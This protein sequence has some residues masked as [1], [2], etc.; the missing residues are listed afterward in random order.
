MKRLLVVAG[1]SL[2][3]AGGCPVPQTSTPT[4]TALLAYSSSAGPAPLTIAFSGTSSTSPYGSIAGYYWDFGDGQFSAAASPFHIFQNPG[5]YNVI[6]TVTD[7]SGHTGVDG[8]EVRVAGGGA[9]AIISVDTQSG[10]APL[11]VHFD[12]TQSQVLDDTVMDY[13]WDFGDLTTSRASKPTHTFG[14]NGE[15]TVALRIVTAGG[16]EATTNTTI[17]VGTRTAALQFSGGDLASLPLPATIQP[18]SALSFEAWV[19][20]AEG[21]LL[22]SLGDGAIT[23]EVLPAT[24]LVRVHANGQVA[25]ASNSTL[26]GQW[27]HIAVTYAIASSGGDPNTPTGSG[28]CTLYVDG[29][30]VST[31]VATQAV[32]VSRITLGAGLRGK[33][34]DVRFWSVARTG[35]DIRDHRAQRLSG[36][37]T[38]L[39][40]YWPL[41]EGSGQTL[42]NPAQP[43]LVGV[44][45]SS[46]AIENS[47]PSWTS[48][49]PPF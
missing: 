39:M 29:V 5:R 38:G 9:V 25:D 14:I 2:L 49:G 45:G 19:K 44:L 26:S 17:T 18:Y 4:V 31:A 43:S 41:S 28:L 12:G 27:H 3:L 33:A 22:A 48:D 10:L 23:V 34:A 37:E 15:Y 21:G 40:G 47:D 13:Y 32:G 35:S 1:A 30:G 16:L 36:S 42:Q 24:S 6:L 7:S 20:A 8:L 46:T 11:T